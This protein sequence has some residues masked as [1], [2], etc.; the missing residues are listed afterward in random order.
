[1]CKYEVEYFTVDVNVKRGS[2]VGVSGVIDARKLSSI[3][4]AEWRQ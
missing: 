1:M 3:C 4:V 2:I